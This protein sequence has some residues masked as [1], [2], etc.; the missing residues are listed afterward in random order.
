MSKTQN[1]NGHQNIGDN[2]CVDIL[3]GNGTHILTSELKI[4]LLLT[5]YW[6]VPIFKVWHK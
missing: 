4:F 6:Y 2:L 1:K 5:T 3:V